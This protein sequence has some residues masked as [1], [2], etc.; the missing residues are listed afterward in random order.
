MGSFLAEMEI[1]Y[2]RIMYYEAWLII[3]HL[4]KEGEIV[5]E[6]YMID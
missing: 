4:S 3:D 5:M 2:L 6:I 1:Y